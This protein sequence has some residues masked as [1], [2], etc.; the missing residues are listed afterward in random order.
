MKKLNKV[1]DEIATNPSLGEEKKAALKG[2]EYINLSH[3]I[4]GFY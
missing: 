3:L 2:Y 4:N 1:E